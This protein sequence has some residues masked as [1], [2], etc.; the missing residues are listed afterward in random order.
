MDKD[1]GDNNE[2]HQLII[3]L[4]P[5]SERDS[6]VYELIKNRDKGKYPRYVDYVCAAVMCF[7]NQEQEDSPITRKELIALLDTYF[8]RPVPVVMPG[9]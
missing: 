7:E 2:L 5:D 1:Y 4:R 9:K 8:E 6:L 3:R